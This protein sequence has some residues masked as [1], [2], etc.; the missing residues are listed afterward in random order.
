MKQLVVIIPF[1]VFNITL[2][3]STRQITKDFDG[4]KKMDTVYIDSDLDKLIC[5]LS[6]NNYKKIESLKIRSLNFGN[7]LVKTKNGFQFWNDYGRSG[8]INEFEYNNNVKKMQLIKIYRTDYDLNRHTYGDLVKN[9]S[10][11]SSVDLKSNTYIGDFYDVYNGKL[12]K[13]PT[14]TKQL[15]FTDT[16]LYCF[17]DDIN[18]EFE[19]KCLQFYEEA[20]KN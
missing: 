11:K 8:W 1:I 20:K 16:F 12:R 7:T 4:D 18:F 14:I 2:A 6:S 15:I 3:Q 10:G 17:S 5:V 19:K 13:L 9:G